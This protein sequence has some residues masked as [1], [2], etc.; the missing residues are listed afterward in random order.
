MKFELFRRKKKEKESVINPQTELAALTEKLDAELSPD[1]LLHQADWDAHVGHWIGEIATDSLYLAHA[2]DQRFP[3]TVKQKIKDIFS[4]AGRAAAEKFST[5]LDFS[6][7][8]GISV[9]QGMDEEEMKK[10]LSEAKNAPKYINA[11]YLEELVK[12][13]DTN[14]TPESITAAIKNAN[15]FTIRA[16]VANMLGRTPEDEAATR[17]DVEG[18][19]A[20][21]KKHLEE[22]ERNTGNKDYFSHL[23]DDIEESKVKPSNQDVVAL[24]LGF[25]L[26]N[27]T[28][29]A[30]QPL[31]GIYELQTKGKTMR[32]N[33]KTQGNFRAF[34]EMV[35]YMH[36]R[37]GL[38]RA[39]FEVMKDL[40][41]L[42]EF[43]GAN[44]K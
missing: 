17:R 42:K 5:V 39:A 3:E 4:R 9:R 18:T 8:N 27:V 11:H 6:A 23:V 29:A 38:D 10:K 13:A 7:Q 21:L 43:G 32:G 41:Q 36:E 31:N 40:E 25:R 20:N 35:R 24:E 14:A 1:M 19:R 33:S 2:N 34:D 30:G 12:A 37:A 44:I 28:W 16:M 26:A 15:F 22:E